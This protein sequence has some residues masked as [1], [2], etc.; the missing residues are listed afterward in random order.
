[1]NP[2]PW[3]F[4]LPTTIRFGCGVSKELPELARC[5]GRRPIVVTGSTLINEPNIA[6]LIAVLDASAVFSGVTPNPTVEQVDALAQRIR[7]E[8]CDVVVAIGGG[9]PM[10]CAKAA[11][12]LAASDAASIR[13]FHSGGRSLGAAHL[14]LIAVPTT[15]GTGSEVTP[16]A[17]LDDAAA[18]LKAP[19]ASPS[20]YP[21]YALVDP[22]LTLS[23]PH[24][25]TAAT[26]LDTLTHALE[27]FW[28]RNHQPLC[29]LAA[30]ESARLVF[31]NLAAVLDTPT[32]LERRENLSYA[33]LLG[34]MAFQ[35]PKNAMVHACSMPLSKRH[36]L[37]HGAACALT[38]EFAIRFNASVI[39]ERLAAFARYCGFVSVEAMIAKIHELKRLGG[40]PC[41]LADAGID[42]DDVAL[43]VAES[44][45]PLIK[46]NPREVRAKDLEQMYAELA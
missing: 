44:F 24:F 38:L 25:T 33:A 39:P 8:Q 46:N 20:L 34:G 28:S 1:M 9:S 4:S 35:L 14:P 12:A 11:S 3:T 10:D 19:L 40:L 21:A 45:H 29:D 31:G 16:F 5:Y 32:A 7:D 13:A 42:I 18:N 26:A 37:A 27:A 43:L 36:H 15:A 17:V 22:E 41:T 23:L 30:Q 6:S 2:T